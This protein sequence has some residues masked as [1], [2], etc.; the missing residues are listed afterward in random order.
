MCLKAHCTTHVT[1]RLINHAS[2]CEEDSASRHLKGN[3][4]KIKVQLSD[5]VKSFKS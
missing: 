1:A 3:R 5:A 2:L 4:A